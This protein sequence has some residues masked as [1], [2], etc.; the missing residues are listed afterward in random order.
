MHIARRTLMG[1]SAA[2]LAAMLGTAGM[3]AL[4]APAGAASVPPQIPQAAAAESAAAWLAGQ[5]A[6]NGS[7][8]GSLSATVNAILALAAAHV[9][10][11][12]AD[13]ALSYVEANAN[14]YITVDSAD[15]PG[16]LAAL[17]LDAH[18]MGVD[19]TSF[20][21]TNL[22]ARLQATEQTSGPDA[23]MFGT[24]TQLSDFFVGTYDQGLAFT[25]LTAAGQTANAAA[26]GWLTTQQCPSGGWAFPNQATGVC[27]EDPSSFEGADDQTTSL[28]VQGLTA[29]GALTAGVSASALS[30]FTSGQDADG[31][32]S[33]YPN[34]V[35]QPQQTD[36]QSTGL[37]IQALLA[38]G[39]APTS[40]TFTGSG[41]SPVSA[42]L[43]F[44]VPEGSDKG[45]L[46][47]QDNAS[48]N[49]L[50]TNQDVAVLAGLT[51]GFGPTNSYW[52][53]TSTGAVEPFGSAKSYGSLTGTVLNKPIV[54][55][56]S[57]LNGLGYWMVASD[58]GLFSYGDAGFFGSRGGQPLNAPI[59]GMAATPDGR[60]YW[61]VASDGGIFGYGDAGFFGSRGGQPLNA[62]IVGMAA[63][64]D[65]GGYWLVAS[66]GG[67]FSYGDAGFLG[68]RGGQPL[69]KPVV[70][71]AATP[72]G[73]G[74]WLVASD[75]GI[76][77]YGDAVFLGSTGSI[78]LNKPIVG[79]AA[80]RDGGGYWLI[81]ADGGIF[82]YGDA[83]FSGSAASLGLTN[84]V[85]GT[86]SAG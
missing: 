27:A 38:L 10:V 22:V 55:M 19:P 57:T 62:P 23:G 56:A 84:A 37:V 12:V 73:G 70:G 63:T 61:L 39:Q 86:D 48:G 68:S 43:S 82:N 31:G 71:M 8:G 17:I 42:L 75:G 58:G 45:A 14:S 47:Y 36:S 7:I 35:A 20:G 2:A 18:A 3:A 33:Y 44:V 5:Q 77:S 16:Q 80:T 54:G 81:A 50:A 76:F 64:A 24:E 11:P 51:Y 49:L 26:I 79:I 13:A 66:D 85:G 52:V 69:N 34:S 1:A 74:Y 21:G 60:G 30:F 83:L 78:A 40:P 53:T 65:G 9:D 67:I 28:A 4:A 15:G 59:V 6:P 25:A 72:D 46:G 29:Q 32:W 41:H